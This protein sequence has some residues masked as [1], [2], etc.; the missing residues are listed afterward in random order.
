MNFGIQEQNIILALKQ[1]K[2]GLPGLISEI[3]IMGRDYISESTA[4]ES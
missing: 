1:I 2:P 4:N 3:V